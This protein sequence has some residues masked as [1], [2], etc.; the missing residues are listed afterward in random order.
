MNKTFYLLIYFLYT[1]LQFV[2][3][4]N[5]QLGIPLGHN[6]PIGEIN[7]IEDGKYV[8]SS[9]SS[10]NYLWS[11]QTGHLIK[12]LTLQEAK[13]KINE[14][15]VNKKEYNLFLEET[16]KTEGKIRGFID[17]NKVVFQQKNDSL[18]KVYNLEKERLEYVFKCGEIDSFN[19]IST[20]S[21]V[22]F[23][24]ISS[25]NNEIQV[26]KKSDGTLV[27]YKDFGKYITQIYISKNSPFF[28]VNF[29]E[30]DDYLL[31]LDK[32]MKTVS[33]DTLNG[34]D[35]V[36]V[37]KTP[38]GED[39][40]LQ[41][42]ST[43]NEGYYNRNLVGYNYTQKKTVYEIPDFYDG[44]CGITFTNDYQYFAVVPCGSTSE[45]HASIGSSNYFVMYNTWSGNRIHSFNSKTEKIR[46]AKIDKNLNHLSV[47]THTGG[48]QSQIIDLTTGRLNSILNSEFVIDALF[49]EDGNYLM[50]EAD[51]RLVNTGMSEEFGL[52]LLGR[53]SKWV[54]EVA[55][56]KLIHI[57]ED[58]H[59]TYHYDFPD[60]RF[61]ITGSY[62][63]STIAMIT[64]KNEAMMEAHKYL[65]GHTQKITAMEI[66]LDNN[67][68]A[69]ASQDR[70]IKIWESETGKELQSIKIDTSQVNKLQFDLKSR[71]LS[72]F[73]SDG[74]QKVW[75][76][77]T[78]NLSHNIIFK[79]ETKV[80]LEES[81]D[82]YRIEHDYKNDLLKVYNKKS[83]ELLH[84]L[85]SHKDAITTYEILEGTNYLLTSSY[86][87]S[88]IIWD[89]LTGKQLIRQF[90][91]DKEDVIWIL[92]N[93][94]YFASKGAS[95]K[96]YYING[97]ESVG[98]EQL[99]IKFNRPDKVLA[100]LNQITNREDSRLI[101]AYKKA[102]EKRVLKLGID[103][104]SFDQ[105]FSVPTSDFKNRTSYTYEQHE[106][107][108]RLTI[109]AHDSTQFLDRYNVW[110]NEVPV[111]GKKG[112][113][114]KD[115]NTNNINEKVSI[116]LS[117]GMNRIETSVINAKGIE[118]YRYPL[119]VKYI[120]KKEEKEK[121]YFIGIGVDEYKDKENNLAYSVKD[122][123]DLSK[124]LKEKYGQQIII[125]T[126]FN[127]QVTVKNVLALKKQ[128]YNSKVDDKVIISFSGHGL[129][130]QNLDYYLATH[131][132]N[133]SAP[134]ENGL[135]YDNLEYLLDSIPAR[136][137]VLFIDAC[138]SGEV[139][140]E[141]I[142]L[143][144][145]A[146]GLEDG[147]KGLVIV[148]QKE[149]KIGLKNSFELM[150]EFFNNVDRATGTT[151]ISAAAGTQFAQERG[152]L[153]NGVF[154]Y[155]ILKQLQLK[156]TMT[157]SELKK[158]VSKHVQE[159]TNGQQQ[160]TSRN[161]TMENDWKIW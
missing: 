54:W 50:M 62:K 136:Q 5:L 22:P 52:E 111:F 147:V 44:V 65:L 78:G 149:N 4:Q 101:D 71:Y 51:Q 45:Y 89:L 143:I 66:S 79:K 121:L 86:D 110:V 133:F 56:G 142:E 42:I 137:K 138:H 39:F 30:D 58:M 2:Q 8:I 35:V 139:D 81:N 157:I 122:I 102:W 97:I 18:C 68:A 70:T 116:T 34:I 85:T 127:D 9:S 15:E 41:V 11:T 43:N 105:G 123:R 114:V 55:S 32:K 33:E 108:I 153:K 27:Y 109:V 16:L 107:K 77:K 100:V 36:D 13:K 88:V 96:L 38:K 37:I 76:I 140:K 26:R 29:N 112:L 69:T 40:I 21:S 144:A 146:E 82:I 132:V 161:E 141:G 135:L 120:P 74:S 59:N 83:G 49:S 47:M 23:F 46:S 48:G 106:K 57:I 148:K 20:S 158:E 60:Q 95:S 118:S 129:L 145:N 115:L 87:G 94:Y 131:D 104:A 31:T 64:I 63:D 117:K 93:G 150:K 75:D 73:F 25:N 99:D 72:A 1:T 19:G 61:G 125:D 128:L 7:F 130:S 84:K 3:A 155:C 6:G 92:P 119:Y 98:F 151:V 156:E 126:L 113:S 17:E 53:H 160:P 80:D 134:E 24:V 28:I 124:A 152:E 10:K 90:I 14:N 159:M 91:F 154:T 67:L 12:E 103:T